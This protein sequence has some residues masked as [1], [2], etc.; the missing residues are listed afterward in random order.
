MIQVEYMGFTFP[1]S[2]SIYVV[3][4]V[5]NSWTIPVARMEI[6]SPSF[7]SSCDVL[8]LSLN[9][10]SSYGTVFGA[11]VSGIIVV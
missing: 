2:I 3:V 5:T 1:P 8:P 7:R 6:V 4:N 11:F 9:C 10:C